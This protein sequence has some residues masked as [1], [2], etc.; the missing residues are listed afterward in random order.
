MIKQPLTTAERKPVMTY[1]EACKSAC[2]DG[3]GKGLPR[4]GLNVGYHITAKHKSLPCTAPS[5]EEYEASL[6]REVERQ[7]KEIEILRAALNTPELHDF[8]KGVVSEA[9]HQRL[10]WGSEHDAGKEP[11][12]WFW[13]LGYLAGKALKA[14]ASGDTEKALHHTISSAAALANWHAAIHGQTNMRPGID[15][16]ERGIAALAATGKEQTNG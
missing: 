16:A 3:C 6:I 2:P 15:P 12:D 11:Q 4:L 7:Q 10:R 5:R 1:L 13:L 14:H 9:Q 8:A